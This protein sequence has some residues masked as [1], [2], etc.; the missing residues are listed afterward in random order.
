LCVDDLILR[1]D[2]RDEFAWV[3]LTWNREQ[4]PECPHCEIL[5]G[6]EAVNRFLS[7]WT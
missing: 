2:E 6:L 5:G 1:L 7:D 3:H 4:R